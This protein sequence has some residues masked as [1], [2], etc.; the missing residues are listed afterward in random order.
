MESS[1]LNDLIF[2]E[3]FLKHQCRIS[4]LFEQKKNSAFR[5][6]VMRSSILDRG[7]IAETLKK[8][9][10]KYYHHV[11]SYLD[12]LDEISPKIKG[13]DG[14]DDHAIY[15]QKLK[16]AHALKKSLWSKYKK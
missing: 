5:T 15:L 9:I 6:L 7:L 8:A 3:Y 10:A 14:L 13:W 1:F 12:I 2:R 4:V 16:K 11:V